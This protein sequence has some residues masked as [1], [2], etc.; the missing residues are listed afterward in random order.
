LIAKR[1]SIRRKKVPSK[2]KP[3]IGDL[4]RIPL[5]AE[6]GAV[7]IVLVL[8]ARYKGR[9]MQLGFFSS[10]FG[11]PNE[12]NADELQGPRICLPVAVL[13]LAVTRGL[14]TVIG[15]EPVLCDQFEVP[16]IYDDYHLF[17]G[18]AIIAHHLFT[19]LVPLGHPVQGCPDE[20]QLS[21]AEMIQYTNL[22]WANP[23]FFEGMLRGVLPEG[24]RLNA[25]GFLEPAS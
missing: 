9:A 2:P 5:N 4:L 3:K 11:T 16:I 15:N 14:L 10:V 19:K 6:C 24:R 23:A 25:K 17:R 18:D 7:R 12:A 1:A 13:S 8:P 20:P 22:G 21:W